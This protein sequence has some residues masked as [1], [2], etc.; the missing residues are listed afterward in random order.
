MPNL[1]TIG[2]TSGIPTTGTGT[3]ST[4]DNLMA[5]LALGPTPVTQFS[6]AWIVQLQ[7]ALGNG[8]SS[9]TRGAKQPLSVEILDAAGNQI[10]NFGG[11]NPVSEPG[12]QTRTGTPQVPV[13]QYGQ[14]KPI[15]ASQSTALLGASGA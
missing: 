10:V 5:Q 8:L 4:I 2:V 12:V 13:D 11:L 1:T 6:N 9:D 15:A 14:Y 7:D 3:V